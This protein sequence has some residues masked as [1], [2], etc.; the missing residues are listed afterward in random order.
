M[1]IDLNCRT[2]SVDIIEVSDRLRHLDDA[3]VGEIAD[4]MKALGQINPIIV[5]DLNCDGAQMILVAGHHRLAAARLIGMKEVDVVIVEGED[6][7]CRLWEIAEN[8][9]RAE[10]ADGE[11]REHIAEWIKLTEAKGVSSQVGTKPN[12]G[13][14]ESGINAAAR[15]IGVKK[16]EAHRAVKIMEKVTAVAVE[17]AKAAGIWDNTSAMEKVA[18]YADDDQVEAV[19]AI[20]AEKAAPKPKRQPE[21]VILSADEYRVAMDEAAVKAPPFVFAEFRTP[22]EEERDRE[23]GAERF[24][25]NREERRNKGPV[26]E[27]ALLAAWTRAPDAERAE[28]MRKVGDSIVAALTPA[29]LHAAHKLH[30]A[31]AEHAR[32]K[33]RGTE[34]AERVKA[35]DRARQKRYAQVKEQDLARKKRYEAES[36]A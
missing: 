19:E 25:A 21:T 28:F 27:S 26:R 32:R 8:L 11:R 34:E 12:G 18:S 23:D 5:R 31:R 20:V 15:E 24:I 4:S 30:N 14:P 2:L 36:A 35:E 7:E 1:N 9:H 13:R 33:G 29:Q 17:A 16:S 6:V 10:L 3:K 22:E